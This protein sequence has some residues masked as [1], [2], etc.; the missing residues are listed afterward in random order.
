MLDKNIREISSAMWRATMGDGEELLWYTRTSSTLIKRDAMQK[1]VGLYI[2][3]GIVAYF[4]FLI[5]Q[6]V[7]VDLRLLE[8]N[9][10]VLAFFSL[11]ARAVLAF[12]FL[13]LIGWLFKNNRRYNEEPAIIAYGITNK[14]LLAVGELGH[15]I[16]QISYGEI[17]FLLFDDD[18]KSTELFVNRLNDPDTDRSFYIAQIDD[19]DDMKH[20]IEQEWK[21]RAP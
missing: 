20:R 16:D 8:A 19:L 10:G 21:K 14:R 2:F 1:N 11:A 4:I 5:I 15:V 12:L 9:F 3:V 7:V 6:G 13:A 18:R 17:D